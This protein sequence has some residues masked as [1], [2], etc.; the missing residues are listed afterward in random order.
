[1]GSPGLDGSCFIYQGNPSIFPRGQLCSRSE[2]LGHP[3]PGAAARHDAAAVPPAQPHLRGPARGAPRS[4]RRSAVCLR[5]FPRSGEVGSFLW[6]F[7]WCGGKG[8]KKEPATCVRFLRLGF[9]C[10]IAA[11]NKNPWG[12]VMGVSFF[13]VGAPFAVVLEGHPKQHRES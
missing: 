3:G 9:R 12:L 11:M 7:F 4:V 2:E 1:M 5:F 13:G 6:F 10:S 8:I